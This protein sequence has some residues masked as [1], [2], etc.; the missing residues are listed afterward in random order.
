MKRL[1]CLMLTLLFCF[2]AFTACAVGADNAGDDMT[3]QL[4]LGSARMTVNGVEKEIDP[5]RN[6][7]PVV[8]NDRTL[9]P[10]RAIVEEMGGEVSWDEASQTAAF[11]SG[12][13]EIRLTVGSRTAYINGAARTLDVA[14]TV[15]DGRTMLPIRFIAESFHFT[16]DWQEASQQITIKRGEGVSAL[17]TQPNENNGSRAVVIYFSATGN[18]ETLAAKVAAA[19]GAD[20]YEILPQ[21]AYTSEDLNYNNDNSRANRE[22]NSDERP[23]IQPLNIDFSQYDTVILGYPIWW[24][25]CPPVVRTF[26]AN[27][28]L[29]GKTIMPFCTSGSSGISGS[30][31]KIR[32]LAPDSTVTDGFRGTGA[33]TESQITTWLT[34]NGFKKQ[35]TGA[36]GSSTAGNTLKIQVGNRTL[37]ATLA[38]NSSVT[39]LKELLA[40]GPV[41][42]DMH[43]YNAMEKVGSLGTTLPRNDVQTATDFGDL[44][45]YQGNS[46]VIYYDKN[47]W[48]FTPLG[49]INDITQAEL[50]AIL[51]DGNV[52][53]TI[54]MD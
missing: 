1:L 24:G 45:L 26:L 46:F 47:N 21:T 34:Q 14:P 44:I 30:L 23:A 31:G 8:V 49:K 19:A 15:M 18:T 2:S 32:E 9:L 40:K 43:D 52:T 36:A 41:T 33:T 35:E 10:A 25:Q 12:T 7:M 29:S 16:V 54:S 37:T 53:V 39:A 28:D 27:T 42:I 4:Q 50:K 5:G 20:K 51:G 22:I 11:T 3:I 6:T 13:E 48:N 17:P 38:D